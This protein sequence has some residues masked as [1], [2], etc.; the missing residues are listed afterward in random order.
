MIWWNNT[1]LEKEGLTVKYEKLRE[2][3][4][5]VSSWILIIV[6][7]LILLQL[8]DLSIDQW[9]EPYIGLIQENLIE[10]S[11]QDSLPY[12]QKSHSPC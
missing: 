4:N 6:K 7:S 9:K 11:V 8:K 1:I 5:R 3:T 10:N 12:M 2:I